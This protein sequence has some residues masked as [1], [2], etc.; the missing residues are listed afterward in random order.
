MSWTGYH[1]EKI[2]DKSDKITT[3]NVSLPLT[4]YKSSAIEL[5]Y[6]LMHMAVEYTQYLNPG[7]IAVGCSDQPLYAL[8][9]NIQHTHPNTL[10]DNYFYFMDELHIEQEL[11]VCIGQQ[12]LDLEW[13]IL[14]ML[15]HQ[16][17]L[18]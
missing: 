16:T 9:K 6:H 17:Q 14:S 15:L 4:N 11:L 13:R 8:K 3:T 10:R 2:R 7:Q 5:Q 12:Q 18:G 1:E